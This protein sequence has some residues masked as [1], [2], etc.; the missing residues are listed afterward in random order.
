MMHLLVGLYA[1]RAAYLMQTDHSLAP[2]LD[3]CPCKLLSYCNLTWWEVSYHYEMKCIALQGGNSVNPPPPCPF[4]VAQ[5]KGKLRLAMSFSLIM[6][7]SV[8][9]SFLFFQQCH[10]R[11]QLLCLFDTV[12]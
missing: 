2:V 3:V 11:M 10:Q 1:C 12:S 8:V 7:N 5:A 6:L 9:F 4:V